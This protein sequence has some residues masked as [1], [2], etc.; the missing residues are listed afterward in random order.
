MSCDRQQCKLLTIY[1][2]KGI[3]L[4]H[5]S[6]PCLRSLACFVYEKQQESD[7]A[8]RGN[9]N[10]AYKNQVQATDGASGRMV[11]AFERW[12]VCVLKDDGP[13]EVSHV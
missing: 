4:F 3:H 7:L 13:G 2:Q 11:Q 1:T 8:K 6:S 10:A 5:S 9:T 12:P